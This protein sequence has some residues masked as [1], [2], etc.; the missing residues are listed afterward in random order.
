MSRR[1]SIS[2]SLSAITLLLIFAGL[3]LSTL[4]VTA[5]TF[6]EPMHITRGYAFVA[7]AADY[8]PKFCSPCSPVLGTSLSG[9]ALLLQP[10]LRLPAA[11]DPIWAAGGDT[12]L[13]ESFMW[14]NTAVPQLIVFL[15]RLPIIAVSWLLGALIYR[16]ARERSSA[17]PAVGALALY[18]FCPN[19]LAHARLATTDVIAA[20]TFALSTY[21][22]VRALERPRRATWLLSGV[23]L[24]LALAAKISAVWLIAAYGGLAAIELWRDRPRGRAALRPIGLVFVTLL[25]GAI[26][27]W[28]VYRFSIGPV[29]PG[30]LPLPA[31][32]YWREWLDFNVYLREPTPGYLFE[33]VSAHG[34]WYYYPI[35]LAVKTP[36]PELIAAAAV[37][38]LVLKH[39]GFRRAAGLWLAPLLLFV[40]LLFS[41][42][43]LGYRYLLPILPYLFVA[44]ADVFAALAQRRWLALG[45]AG[46]IGWQIAGTLAIYPYYLTYFND[47]VGGPDRGRYIL[48]DSNLDWGQDLIGLKA[49]VDQH[50]ID[51]LKFS[52]FGA[53]DPAAYG[54]HTEA[55]PPV[56]LAMH[57]QSAWWLHTYHPADP[58]PGRYAISVTS[59]MGGIWTDR[60]TYAYFRALQPDAVIG[61]SIYLYTV[62]ARGAPADL[63]L[64][65]LQLDQIDAAAYRQFGTNDVRPRWFDATRSI[66]AAPGQAWLAIAADQPPAPELAALLADQTPAARAVTLDDQRPYAL[67]HFD[68]ASRLTE[69]ARRAQPRTP[70]AV[71]PVQFAEAASLIGYTLERAGDQISVVTYWQA[72]AHVPAPLQLFVHA[73]GPEGSIVAQEDRLDVSAY[74]WRSGDLFAQVNRLSLPAG[75]NL[76]ALTIGFYDPAT[77]ARLPVTAGGRLLGDQLLLETAR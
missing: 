13:I 50:Q 68:L 30:G 76:A 56:A 2:P 47:L 14:D 54:L 63:A 38:L 33:Q 60:S 23:A 29:V 48:S 15:A 17:W 72:G 27:L 61:H 19:I 31:P 62:L 8:V 22:F 24:G 10:D 71:L 35:T 73:L 11:D 77:G 4:D 46:L 42:H 70:D 59:L 64:A 52:Y 16:W 21:A 51:H 20:A 41:P 58:P 9:L 55:L 25:V 12:G 32:A 34:W 40:S 26:T 39:R 57:R 43:D 28:G 75:A 6:D 1:L 65:G 53:T 3:Q 44:G 66:V 36:L 37:G 18:V 7:R 45:A 5:P 49:Y 74:G 69:A 67:Y